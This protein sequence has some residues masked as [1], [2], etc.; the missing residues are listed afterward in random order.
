MIRRAAIAIAFLVFGMSRLEAQ[1]SS[2][3]SPVPANAADVASI[4]SIIAALYDVISGPAGQKRDWDRFRSLFAPDARLIPTGKRADG[5]RTMRVLSPND[6]AA[7]SGGLETNGFFEREITRRVEQFG[8]VAHVFSTYESRR[9]AADPMPFARGIN[10]IQ[11]MHNGT[12]WFV[13]TIFWDSERPDN[14]IP[15]K[16]LPGGGAE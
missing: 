8:N 1:P 4:E 7:N 15:A 12:R 5:T 16:Y 13:V 11:L 6:Y 14:P 9:T 3:A 10:S 2:V